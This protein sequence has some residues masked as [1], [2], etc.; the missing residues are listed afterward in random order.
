[1]ADRDRPRQ[2]ETASED[3][4]SI[5]A[6]LALIRASLGMTQVNFA[7]SIDV[8][9]RSY[10]HYEKG[11]RSL[12]ADILRKL[13]AE[14]GLNMNWLLLGQGLPYDGEDT[15]AAVDFI[16]ELNA[17]LL[18]SQTTLSPE[19]QKRIFAKWLKSLREGYRT[20]MREVKAWVDLLSDG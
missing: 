8:S 14:Y 4:V 7:K 9:L 18:A 15:A 19:S 20:D 2:S 12:S 16:E 11:T 10:H 6:R 3:D 13:R 5:G 17:Y 1:M